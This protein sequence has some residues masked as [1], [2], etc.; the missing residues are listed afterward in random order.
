MVN[1]NAALIESDKS[2][3]IEMAWEDRTT[4][5]SIK[6]TY[7]LDEPALMKLMKASLKLSSYKLWR[8][9]VKEK[10]I[11]HEK[12]RAAKVTRAYCPTQYKLSR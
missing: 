4:F 10:S 1:V 6:T 11:K 8:K 5:E 7:G 12:L 3:I 2:R 9:R